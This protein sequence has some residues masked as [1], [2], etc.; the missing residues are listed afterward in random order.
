[1]TFE[2][3]L[4]PALEIVDLRREFHQFFGKPVRDLYQGFTEISATAK[5]G[6]RS[7]FL[8]FP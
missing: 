6:E 4:R 1:M 2:V 7:A 5:C 3:E 8:L